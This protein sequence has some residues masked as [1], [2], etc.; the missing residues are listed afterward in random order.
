[1]MQ[2]SSIS[3]FNFSTLTF[4]EK[5]RFHAWVR[6]NHCDCRL[7]DENPIAF[8]A[9][10][11][12]APLGPLIISGRKWLNQGRAP[13]YEI[14]RTERLARTD[15]HDFFRFG[16]MLRGRL[17]CWSTSQNPAKVAGDL[18]VVDAAQ[19]NESLV[20]A[21][22]VIS[23][24]VPRNLLPGRTERLHGHTLSSG[25][26]RLLGDHMISV[27]RNLSNLKQHEIPFVVQ[28]TM[29]L[30]TA[31]VSS[32]SDVL[33]EAGNATRDLLLGRIRRYI[34]GHLLEA[35]LTPDRICRDVGVSRAK[36]YQLFESDG[37]VMRQIQR[38]RLW[39]AYHTLADPNRARRHVAEIA[40]NHGFSN[41]KYFYRL[42][43]AEFGHTPKETLENIPLHSLRPEPGVL[44]C[45][46]HEANSPAGWT[47]PFGVPN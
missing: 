44:H 37:G 32:T 8:N 39:R 17:I 26:A 46:R 28:S 33:H 15:G 34:D 43:K 23:L 29:Q 41:E 21:D 35:D 4:P 12:G 40:W 20:E 31:A 9:E 2:T 7:R 47:L 6:D 13:A 24:L 42:F 19:V 38:R 5:D 45:D 36:L 30:V 16:L 3:I 10:A 18:F 27:Y 25:A 1:M 11:T 22:D 14:R